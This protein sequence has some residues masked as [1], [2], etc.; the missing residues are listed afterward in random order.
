[1]A[2]KTTIQW[3]RDT[4]ANWTTVN[5][6]LASGE[7]GFETDT[8]KFKLGDGTTAWSSLTYKSEPGAT[9]ATGATGPA[10]ADGA[11]G[12]T[13]PAGA[14][15]AAGAAGL[16]TALPI[17]SGLYYT[18]PASNSSVTATLNIAF[19]IPIFVPKTTTFDRIACRTATGFAGS[20]VVRL[21]IYS[22]LNGQPDTLVLDAGTIS[23]V[24][25]NT[26]FQI[27]ISQS[28]TAG[29][30]WLVFVSQ[31]NAT[32][33]TY[34]SSTTSYLQVGALATTGGGQAIGW[35]ETVPT[36]ALE[37]TVSLN[38]Q[39]SNSPTVWLRSA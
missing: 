17:T 3:R 11:T 39:T 2:A 15:G 18:T 4:A 36:G 25:S 22:D 13:G 7:A 28:L 30:Y 26:Q 23:A 21:G 8:N 27:T 33:N 16:G 20:G 24:S 31:T 34:R 29:L 10:G 5:P 14:D 9:G 38:N 32:T 19:H 6:I 12:A 1:M 35:N 37:A